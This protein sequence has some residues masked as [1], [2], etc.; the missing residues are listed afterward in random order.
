MATSPRPVLLFDGECGLCQALV[1]WMIRHD[2]RGV[3][4][5]APLQGR[6]GQAFMQSRGLDRVDFDSLVFI[7]DLAWS[8]S[9]FHLRSAGALAA[10]NELGGVSRR[11]ARL[12]RWV[13]QAWLDLI[14]RLVGR[15]RCRLFGRVRSSSLLRPEEA[16]RILD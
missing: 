15:L 9:G 11:L 1:R 3:L 7:V 2:R 13:P 4:L 14:Y 12:L 6:T 5:F 10:L 8:G 16:R